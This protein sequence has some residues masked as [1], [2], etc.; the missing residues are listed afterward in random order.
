M[1]SFTDFHLY[2]A[3]D[4]LE[5]KLRDRYQELPG[6]GTLAKK[7]AYQNT[8]PF[9]HR[10]QQGRSLL[11]ESHRLPFHTQPLLLF[12]GLTHLL[13]AIILLY[14]PTYPASTNVLAHGVSTRKR[15]RK[16]YRFID[17]EVKIQK[18]GLFPHMLQEMFHVKSLNEERFQMGSLFLQ[19]PFI[20]NMTRVDPRFQSKKTGTKIPPLLIHYMLLYNLSMINRYETEW[21]GELIA[22]RTS[23]DL[24]LIEH[25]IEKF[26]TACE[27]LTVGE[28]LTLLE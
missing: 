18:H 12:Y 10:W 4:V 19:L 7:Y 27:D 14:D 3:T 23:A 9:L 28:V 21:W 25:Y 2:T 26:P 13:K 5:K 22:Q 11:T 20:V 15:K 6:H 8:L 24:P 1:H 16:D 17:D